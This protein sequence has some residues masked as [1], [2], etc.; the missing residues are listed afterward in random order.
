MS[1]KQHNIVI[2][3]KGV[4]TG[5]KGV[6]AEKNTFFYNFL[7]VFRGI[8]ST[9][10]SSSLLFVSL[11]KFKGN[12]RI[13][14][15]KFIHI[16]T[17]PPPPCTLVYVFKIP[18]P[19]ERTFQVITPRLRQLLLLS[20]SAISTFAEF[21]TYPRTLKIITPLYKAAFTRELLNGTV[22]RRYG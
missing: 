13:R 11:T 1:H 20:I 16:W 14:D 22:P 12:I 18:P 9:I 17:P 8:L 10:A 6:N 15:L 4:R 2:G 19:P 7:R 3:G 5:R 21:D